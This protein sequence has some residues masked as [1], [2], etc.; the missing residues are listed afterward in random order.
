MIEWTSHDCRPAGAADELVYNEHSPG[1]KTCHY[2]VAPVELVSYGK[3]QSHL[4]IYLIAPS[5]ATIR[6]LAP[7]SAF[8]TDLR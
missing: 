3:I 6:S 4:I 1:N 2:H 8:P 5:L 7:T